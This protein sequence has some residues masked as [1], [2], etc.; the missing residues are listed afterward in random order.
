MPLF[1]PTRILR[2]A[3]QNTTAIKWSETLALPK[4]HFPAR[5]TATQ[6]ERYR[7]RCADELYAWQRA[8]RP[9]KTKNGIGKEVNNEFV[10]HDGP[11]Y[12]NGAVHV[13]HAL[14]KVLKDLIVRWH[15]A[16]GKRVQYRPGWDCHG[17]PIELKALQA[18]RTQT[19]QAS[20]L[21]DAPKQEAAAAATSG[22]GMSATDIRKVARELA[23]ET[24][25]KQKTS[26]KEWGVMGEWEE[27]YKTMNLDFEIGQLRVFRE[28]VRKGL[29]SRHHRPVYWSPS[30]RTALA[31]AELEYDDNHKCTAAFVSMPFVRLPRAL[32]DHPGLKS[33][34]LSALIWT[35][36]PWTLPA[37]KAI[38]VNKDID[39][40]VIAVAQASSPTVQRQDE[41]LLV[42]KERVE[43]VLS[44]LGNEST[45]TTIVDSV[46]GSELADGQATCFN[47][48]TASE[49]PILNADF[50]TATSGT[51]VVHCAPGHGMEDYLLCEQNHIG[52]AVAPVDDGGRYT[53]DVFPA[54]PEM[55]KS[56][57]GLDVQ[58]EGAKA[59]LSV[60]RDSR[61]FIPSEVRVASYNLVLAT[62]EFTHKNP[63][64]WRT[65]QPVIVR[66]TAQWFADVSAIK[67]RA[68]AAL[69]DVTFIP[70]SG[71]TRLKSFV[72]GRSQWC[73]SRQ[74]AWGVPIPALYHQK[75]G[76]ACIREESIDH[77]IKTI[78]EKGTDAWFS[79]PPD[80]P[81][82]IHPSL[83]E[84]PW[85]RGKDTM[86]V[87]FDSGTTWTT[88]A[89]QKRRPV[90]DVYLEGT[91]QHRGWFQSS[92]LTTI[93]TQE[94]VPAAP[95][96]TL[97]TH[98]F[99]LDS[100][101]RKMS[102]SLGN[103]IS[104]DQIL[105]GLLLPPIKAKKQRGKQQTSASRTDGPK[106]D[107]MGP[108]VLRLWVASSDYTRDVSI[109]VPVLQG[110]QQALQK[111]RVT[112]KFLL[113]VLADYNPQATSSLSSKTEFAFADRA[114]LHLLA[115]TSAEVWK[116][117]NEY[118][119]YKV[120]NEI[121]GF[122]NNDLSAFYF[123][124]VKDTMY[125]GSSEVRIR[126]QK[127]L[128]LILDEMM[129]MLGPI[130]PHLIEE[131]WDYTPGEMKSWQDHPLKRV[132]EEP[133]ECSS[134]LE[135]LASEGKIEEKLEIFRRLSAAVK[136]VQEE[137]RTAG[138][139]GSG[140]ACKVEVHLPETAD[141][142]LKNCVEK[143]ASEGEL[144]DLLVVS[145]VVLKSHQDPD[146]EAA[147]RYGNSFA[148]GAHGTEGTVVV[149]PPDK[150][151]CVRCWK[152]TAEESEI[153]CQR[154]RNVLE[155]RRL[156]AG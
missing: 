54:E 86:D 118:R 38:A 101:G 27:P 143:W 64:D 56:M 72:E 94:S 69:E 103:V 137:A 48:F 100:E 104:P 149:L 155:E 136:V 6:L 139:L 77:I 83:A 65:K 82:W 122:V 74:R 153:P 75:T 58:T 90:S 93:A 78:K 57:E 8:S 1:F 29:I 42:A 96:G 87:W 123:E 4:S 47:L 59:V 50:V 49:S 98:G 129:K 51:G 110:F 40:T 145:Q 89:D 62:H 151:K 11:P 108:D 22:V 14:N 97:V 135:N 106:Y 68:L 12:A 36:T 44:H 141:S 102:K 115:R 114:V 25:E 19:E 23:S 34:S 80:N 99:T 111:L 73:I 144:A 154:C 28:M 85:V 18:Q 148:A 109:S 152:Y 10:L 32:K 13:G 76:E 24:I 95:F 67:D 84:D 17:L 128:A 21:R 66:A 88:L 16:T 20:S 15:L 33:G 7:Q 121:N 43:H 119:F 142:T 130:T 156:H 91:D 41:H 113:G 146:T 105:D 52:P 9:Q 133:H 63:T 3:A 79:D 81:T 126:T 2:A 131:V 35:T 117:Y 125:A 112:F 5:P 61:R 120:V 138:H 116:A 45:H 150:E 46:S 60:L 107:A 71:K 37:N 26:F 31:E 55:S 134:R 147:W 30:S 132:W 124:I 39:Y 53:T 70:E 92:L 140:L 127:V